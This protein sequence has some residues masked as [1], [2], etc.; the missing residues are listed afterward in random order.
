MKPG[1]KSKIAGFALSLVLLVAMAGMP[2]PALANDAV[3]LTEGWVSGNVTVASEN[4]T[5]VTVSA[6][7]TD[8]VFSAS[9]T[10]SSVPGGAS[11]IAYTLTVES[12]RAY[13]VIG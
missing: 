8:G 7:D 1:K 2:A 4:I 6:M 13:Y 10:Y 5:Q 3:I 12:D 11:S 9:V